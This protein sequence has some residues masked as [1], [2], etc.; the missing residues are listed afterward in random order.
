MC[1]CTRTKSAST[2]YLKLHL[3]SRSR[4]NA[5]LLQDRLCVYPSCKR[6]LK[7]D[8]D[9]DVD[10]VPKFV[11][12]ANAAFTE[13]P[14]ASDPE[15]DAETGSLRDCFDYAVLSGN[16]AM[17]SNWFF[18]QGSLGRMRAAVGKG[19]ALNAM[20]RYVEC[21]EEGLFNIEP[22]QVFA[23]CKIELG[24][25]PVLRHYYVVRKDGVCSSLRLTSTKHGNVSAYNLFRFGG[26]SMTMLSIIVP[27]HNSE[28]KCGRLLGTLSQIAD[29]EVELI[30]VDDG[31][32]DATLSLLHDFQRTAQV[33][34]QV[35]TQENR[36]PGGARNTGLRAARGTYVWFV[37]SDDDILLDTIILL[38]EHHAE[39]YD[40]I[41]FNV[42][43]AGFSTNSMKVDVGVQEDPARIRIMLL[44]NF[45]RICSKMLRR[46]MLLDND[47][48]YPEFCLYE[49]NPL[50]F[51]LP[52]CIRKF[53]KSP[54]PG[55]VH[56][57]EHASI[58]RSTVSPRY[59]DRMQTAKIGHLRAAPLAQ[60][61]RERELLDEKFIQLYLV[62]TSKGIKKKCFPNGW[63]Y[64]LRLMRQYRHT[65]AILGISKY[66]FHAEQISRVKR[67]YRT[68][69]LA[70]YRLS[71]FL[72]R[73]D[74]FFY[75]IR[76]RA[77]GR[78]WNSVGD[79]WPSETRS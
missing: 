49:D 6:D 22:M 75:E 27:F 2:I 10:I 40:F 11:P 3:T 73:Q 66:P 60:T 28:G 36:G 63:F 52:F 74:V 17:E 46:Q 64:I 71:K 44:E 15:L 21:R 38:K 23:F 53:L 5:E 76:M 47:V 43:D 65:A 59:F 42:M 78:S 57:K 4:P 70:L 24:G 16:I 51:I 32:T 58:T 26:Q 54:I 18:M 31:S 62:N 50:T 20:S 56:N 34:T 68:A 39:G 37:D 12:F 25:H 35:V 55:Y 69:F 79:Q 72:P 13:G 19:I 61:D 45:G 48:T 30:L 29:P 9:Y 1:S 33:A 7:L 77:W 8:R 67:K 41:D 14:A